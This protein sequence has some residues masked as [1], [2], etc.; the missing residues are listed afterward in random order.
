MGRF[1]QLGGWHHS[2]G[3]FFLFQVAKDDVVGFQPFS[4]CTCFAQ[5]EALRIEFIV[6]KERRR[7][8]RSVLRGRS[9]QL[10]EVNH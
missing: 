9:I 6:N 10:D 5:K 7:K 3:I 2:D 1:C 8:E 4:H